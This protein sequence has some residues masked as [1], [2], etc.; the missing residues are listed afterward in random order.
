MKGGIYKISNKIN[1]KV[2]IGQSNNLKRRFK[3]HKIRY[4]SINSNEYNS[5]IHIA[6]RKYNIENF[7]FEIIEYCENSKLNEREIFWINYY[8]SFKNGY[9]CTLG[10]EGSKRPSQ[11]KC[12]RCGKATSRNFIL[13]I[14]CSNKLKSKNINV[15]EKIKHDLIYTY[16]SFEIISLENK[17]SQRCVRDINRGKTWYDKNVKYPLRNMKKHKE[18]KAKKCPQCGKKIHKK[19]ALCISCHNFNKRKVVWPSC[20][21]LKQLI[22]EKPFTEIAKIYKVSD[23]AV[24][25]W[26]KNY[27]LI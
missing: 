9:N 26:C 15:I 1:G 27:N 12:S 10:G 13:C 6:I 3:E 16:K 7:N 5:V 20:D 21:E 19:S 11:K 14:T 2:Y 23:N 25:K 22:T 4:K 18:L 17:V 8:D 24:R